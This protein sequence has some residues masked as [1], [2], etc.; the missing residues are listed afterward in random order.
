MK[1][2]LMSHSL[3]RAAVLPVALFVFGGLA[4]ASTP[5]TKKAPPPEPIPACN[6]WLGN[7]KCCTTYTPG[8]ACARR[9]LEAS[10][11]QS[12]AAEFSAALEA[13]LGATVRVADYNPGYFANSIWGNAVTGPANPSKSGGAPAPG[14]V[15]VCGDKMCCLLTADGKVVCA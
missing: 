2:T 11:A 9:A 3:F 14:A 7:G 6:V 8:D 5:Q 10:A 4:S 1:K 13:E 12:N 15:L